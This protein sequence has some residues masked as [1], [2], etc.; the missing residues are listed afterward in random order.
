MN[1]DKPNEGR[2][3]VGAILHRYYGLDGRSGN[4][5]QE[6]AASAVLRS[7]EEKV[8]GA[9][10]E[11]SHIMWKSP[12]RSNEMLTQEP[13]DVSDSEE[14][15]KKS[16]DFNVSEYFKKILQKATLNDLI[17]KAK[18]I[19]KEIKQKDNFMQSVVYENY[20]KFIKAADTIVNLKKNF[21]NVKEKV[22]NINEH[23][24]CIDNNSHLVNNKIGKNYKK[25]KCLLQIKELLNGVHNIMSIPRRMFD[26]II[27]GDYTQSLQLFIEAVPFFYDNRDMRIFRDLYLDSEN[28]ASIACYYYEEQLRKGITSNRREHNQGGG[29][30]THLDGNSVEEFFNHLC[31]EVISNEEI[32]SSLYLILAY[33]KDKKEVR[34][35]FLWNRFTTMKYLLCEITNWGNYIQGGTT[36]DEQDDG[37]FAK[38]KDYPHHTGDSTP[39]DEEHNKIFKTVL[40]LAYTKWLHFFFS[41][42]RSY[43]QLFLRDFYCACD[44]TGMQRN[45]RMETLGGIPRL[46]ALMRKLHETTADARGEKVGAFSTIPSTHR[47]GVR[48]T[49]HGGNAS[50]GGNFTPINWQEDH[51]EG[52]L[53]MDDDR[54][55]VELLLKIF[56]KLLEDLTVDLI[57]MFNPPVK[58]IARCVRVLQEGVR[59]AVG[60]VDNRSANL[61]NTHLSSTNISNKGSVF[62]LMD[63]F[64]KRINSELLKF[65]VYRLCI[66]NDRSLMSFFS[67][68]QEKEASYIL[69]NKAELSHHILLS[70]CLVLIDLEAF[71]KEIP[72][73]STDFYFKNL[74]NFVIIYFIFLARFVDSFIKYFVCV[75]EGRRSEGDE[76][77]T[78]GCTSYEED[79]P[80]DKEKI[81]QCRNIYPSQA[82]HSD[83]ENANAEKKKKKNTWKCTAKWIY[84]NI[85]FDG[86]DFRSVLMERKKLMKMDL[87]MFIESKIKKHR[88]EGE[89][90]SEINFLFT[91]VGIL[92]SMKKEGVLK[93]FTVI[94]DMYKE[95]HTLVNERK[96]VSLRSTFEDLLYKDSYPFCKMEEREEK[97]DPADA[98]TDEETHSKGQPSIRQRYLNRAQNGAYYTLEGEDLLDW[99]DDHSIGLEHLTTQEDAEMDEEGKFHSLSIHP[100]EEKKK[101]KMKIRDIGSGHSVEQ[102][103]A[104]DDNHLLLLGRSE[105]CITSEGD[106]QCQSGHAAIS[107][108]KS[109]KVEGGKATRSV[110]KRG[111]KTVNAQPGDPSK[112]DTF[113]GENPPEGTGSDEIRSD[114]DNDDNLDDTNKYAVGIR[115]FAKFKFLEKRNELMNAF[116]SYYL[117]KMSRSVKEFIQ[118]EKWTEGKKTELVSRNF[119]YLLNNIIAVYSYLASF[120]ENKVTGT[121]AAGA[122]SASG[123]TDHFNDVKDK[124]GEALGRVCKEYAKGRK[125]RRASSEMETCGNSHEGGGSYPGERRSDLSNNEQ[126]ETHDEK[127]LEMYMY[128]LYMCKMKNYK[129]NL[130]LEK[131]KIILVIIKILFKNYSEYVRDLH[132][133]EYGFEKLRVNFF[134]FFHCL[135]VFVPM[136]DE[137]VL[138]VILNEV[139]ISAYERSMNFTL[140][141]AGVNA[142][143][144]AYLLSEIDCDIEA[145]RDFIMNSLRRV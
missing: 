126:K 104:Q 91:L 31:E 21:G 3:N 43:E 9:K 14:L 111:V 64:H 141:N 82:Y 25:I 130:H 62:H 109:G 15:N 112:E 47:G 35:V 41:M 32:T 131:K 13:T 28:M 37:P 121:V 86:G 65:H 77:T 6:Q 30:T 46:R 102:K 110:G 22:R 38:E 60:E 2:K 57:Y 92:D 96:R 134:F 72:L 136:D 143:Y 80:V 117:N 106:E 75:Q 95:A 1:K 40:E 85:T 74:I 119:I 93:V 89:K 137:H 101:D 114:D 48:T 120:L 34:N 5:D 67:L 61:R 56:F 45:G 69:E 63:E 140:S 142:L 49:T 107:I 138:F 145:N 18:N 83:V 103:N 116:V 79:P 55:V 24:S 139:L 108:N 81:F 52:I 7:K 98:C 129:R 128:K 125:G 78:D 76:C 39:H 4:G 127:N 58:L 23:L 16:T 33:G 17:Q 90:K 27:L 123:Q 97:E 100:Q 88:F 26:L 12:K 44:E 54:E 94:V 144:Q 133:N 66:Q 59:E 68:C 50:N 105:S 51:L 99:H 84:Q 11:E 135:K 53:N 115:N 29:Q 71:Y 19:E 124:I 132:F 36:K 113:S 20:N 70:L 8:N 73:K 122:S 118:R 10:E 42:I 87:D